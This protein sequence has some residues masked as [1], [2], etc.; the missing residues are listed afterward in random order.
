MCLWILIN[1]FGSWGSPNNKKMKKIIQVMVN[2][3]PGIFECEHCGIAY[4]LS[5]R[6]NP[7]ATNW[8]CQYYDVY[9]ERMSSKSGLYNVGVTSE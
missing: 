2:V 9:Y 7:K 3:R 5:A 6:D 4:L 8:C 1:F